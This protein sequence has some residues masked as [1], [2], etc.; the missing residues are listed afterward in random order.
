MARGTEDDMEEKKSGSSLWTAVKFLIAAAAVCY[1]VTK[2]YQKI[3]AKRA[4]R[5]ER[6]ELEEDFEDIDLGLEELAIDEE[7]AIVA[8]EEA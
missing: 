4:E 6:A 3:A 1:L 7:E 8:E 5:A 2:I